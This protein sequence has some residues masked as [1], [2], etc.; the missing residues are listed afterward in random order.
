MDSKQREYLHARVCMNKQRFYDTSNG[1]QFHVS[2][3]KLHVPGKYIF[4]ISSFGIAT[5]EQTVAAVIDMRT[6]C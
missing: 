3:S 5:M 4:D 6:L 2:S 1:E